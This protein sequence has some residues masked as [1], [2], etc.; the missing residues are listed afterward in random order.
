MMEIKDFQHTRKSKIS[1]VQ[2]IQRISKYAKNPE[3]FSA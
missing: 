2:E 3:D 1:G